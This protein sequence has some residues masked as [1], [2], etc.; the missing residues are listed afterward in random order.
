M[1]LD[2]IGEVRLALQPKL[3]GVIAHFAASG[4]CTARLATV[5][6]PA[7]VIHGEADPPVRRAAGKATAAAIPGAKLVT[8]PR[9]GHA[10]PMAM[11]PEILDAITAHARVAEQV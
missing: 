7:L 8:I 6:V 11:W 9:M 3:L 5:K 10:M 1:F 2:E 4:D